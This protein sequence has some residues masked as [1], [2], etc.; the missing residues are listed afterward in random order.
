VPRRPSLRPHVRHPLIVRKVGATFFIAL[1][2]NPTTDW[3]RNV[4]AVGAYMIQLQGHWY[5]AGDPR[6][7][8]RTIA[9]ASFNLLLRTL[10]RIMGVKHYLRLRDAA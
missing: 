6:I 9:P 5:R 2:Y 7:V 10:L 3:C 8:G 4:L 1:T